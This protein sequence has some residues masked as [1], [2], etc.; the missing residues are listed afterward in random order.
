MNTINHHPMNTDEKNCF[1]PGN[2]VIYKR[3]HN[4][5]K[6]TV[7]AVTGTMIR[8]T[9]GV[10]FAKYPTKTSGGFLNREAFREVGEYGGYLRA[11]W[12]ERDPEIAELW[13]TQKRCNRM[14]TKRGE[15]LKSI[16]HVEANI[17]HRH[18]ATTPEAEAK[19]NALQL[20]LDEFLDA[21]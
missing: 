3:D 2:V 11:I 20:A 7:E 18:R 15:I 10:R 5:Y 13:E 21:E 1:E 14:R 12:H 16:D 17:R 9:N 4:F 19:L 6:G 8:L